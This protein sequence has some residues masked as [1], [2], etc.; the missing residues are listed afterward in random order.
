MQCIKSKNVHSTKYVKS[1]CVIYILLF[2]VTFVTNVGQNTNKISYKVNVLKRFMSRDLRF[3]PD[4]VY[5]HSIVHKQFIF[6]F[7]PALE[8]KERVLNTVTQNFLRIKLK[9]SFR[10]C[11]I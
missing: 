6:T 8:F 10:I 2:S 5:C 11:L 1:Y 9:L 3:I 4:K 7:Q